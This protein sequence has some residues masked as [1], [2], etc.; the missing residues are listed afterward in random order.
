MRYLP[1]YFVKGQLEK[2]FFC[3]PDPHFKAK[4]HRRRIISYGLLSEYAY[5]IAPGGRLY[6]ITDVED[7]HNW[8]VEKISSHAL[9]KRLDDE[10]VMR[11]DPAVRAMYDETEEGIKVAR[12]GGKKFYA[13]YERIAEISPDSASPIM[14]LFH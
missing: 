10:E 3:F 4:N 8:H 14:S 7:L 5:F 13:V 11:N 6:T 9:F 2:V 1:N 12:N